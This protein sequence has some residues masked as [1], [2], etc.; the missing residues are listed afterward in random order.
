M[1]MPSLYV[2]VMVTALTVNYNTPDYLERLLKSFRQFYDIPYVVVDGST[3]EYYKIIKGFGKRFKVELIHFDYNIHHGP[4]M[5]HGL[6]HIT[7]E[8]ALL[9]DSDMIIHAGGWLEMMMKE[10]RSTSYGIGDVQKEFYLAAQTVINKPPAVAMSTITRQFRSPAGAALA[11]RQQRAVTTMNKVWV[12]YLHPAFAL[13]NR[14]VM[15][16]YPLPIKGGAPLIAAMKQIALEHNSDKMLQRAQWLTDDL[17]NHTA[18]YVQ[19]NEN[20]AGMGTVQR[21][22]GY[23]L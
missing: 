18:R 15:L 17:W 4:G 6:K 11:R 13:V 19:H 3:S 5:I 1:I 22:G 9:V 12:D 14:S 10:L 23:H 8:R 21:T 7:S 2:F 20:H 16:R